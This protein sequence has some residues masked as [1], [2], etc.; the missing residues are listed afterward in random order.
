MDFAGCIVGDGDLCGSGEDVEVFVA[1]GVKVRGHGSIDAKDAAA[2]CLSIGKAEVGE[3]RLCGF[4][5]RAGESR[6]IEELAFGGHR[7][8]NV[9][10]E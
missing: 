7:R 5:E 1:A 4:G 6:Y 9:I 2:C 8:R 10:R 3:H